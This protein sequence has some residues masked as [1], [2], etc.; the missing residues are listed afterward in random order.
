[1]GGHYPHLWAGAIVL[2]GHAESPLTWYTP[3]LDKLA[4]FKQHLIRTD[5]AIDQCENFLNIP[6]QIFHGKNDTVVKPDGARAMQAG[7][8]AHGGKAELTFV[9]GDHWSLFDLMAS[10]PPVKK[11]LESRKPE[12]F[13]Q[14]RRV[15]RS[16]RFGDAELFRVTSRQTPLDPFRIEWSQEAGTHR[17]TRLEGP[18]AALGAWSVKPE[19]KVTWPSKELEQKFAASRTK[20]RGV[21]QAATKGK[22]PQRCGP[23]K[24]ATYG[25]F[26]VT[27]GTTAGQDVTAKLKGRAERF[28]KWWHDFAKGRVTV[29]ADK[30]VTAEDRKNKSLFI[31]GEEQEHALHAEAAP[32][33]P[34]K[35]RDHKL[36]VG[37]RTVELLSRGVLYIYP[38][39]FEGAKPH[40]SVVIATGL[41]YGPNLPV[42]HR[43][44]LVPDFLVFEHGPDVDGTKTNKP[45]LAGFFDGAWKLDPKTTWWSEK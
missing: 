21:P 9:P 39:P 32:N 28:A 11:M 37:K 43:L 14:F 25:P 38:S 33:L 6:V 19:A 5:Q 4:P 24:E 8:K 34:F 1:M 18:V 42:N 2:A 20:L 29:K 23:V 7:I 35:I 16:L 15:F 30:D 36:T 13:T 17:I 45:V 40:C 31:F 41:P 27:Y 12:S 10:E 3:G 44:D 26:I 22:T